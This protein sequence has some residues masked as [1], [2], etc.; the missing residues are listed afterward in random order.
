MQYIVS[1]QKVLE[2]CATKNEPRSQS[3][4]DVFKK[5]ICDVR[6]TNSVLAVAQKLLISTIGERDY[7]SQ[8]TCHIL[9]QLPMF[10]ASKNY[11]ILSL[12]GSHM[13]QQN[14]REGE[15][16][17]AHLILDHYIRRPSSYSTI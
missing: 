12:D 4:R 1:R 16:A 11:V 15:L 14:S 3:M 17:T 9:L 7:S 13:I 5:I 10:K 8:E 6:P 2:Y